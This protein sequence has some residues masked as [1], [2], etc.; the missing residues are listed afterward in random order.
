LGLAKKG[1]FFTFISIIV[2]SIFMVVF[3]WEP[4]SIEQTTLYSERGAIE[5]ATSF[6]QDLYHVYLPRVILIPDQCY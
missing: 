3:S 1:F 6:T 5:V 4:E 2:L